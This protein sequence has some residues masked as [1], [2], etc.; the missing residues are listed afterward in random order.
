[1]AQFSTSGSS[2]STKEIR[3]PMQTTPP[4]IFVFVDFNH[5]C[6]VAAVQ[7]QINLIPVKSTLLLI[8]VS[9]AGS[10]VVMPGLSAR[11]RRSRFRSGFNSSDE[12]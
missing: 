4:K 10:I 2:V 3:L 6:K 5:F 7:S 12:M 1:M 8:L 9:M 11:E